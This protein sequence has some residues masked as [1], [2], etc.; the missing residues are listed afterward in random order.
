VPRRDF[1]LAGRAGSLLALLALS[2]TVLLATPA[3]ASGCSV[4]RAQRGRN[5]SYAQVSAAIDAAAGRHRVPPPLLKAIAWKESGWQ[6]FWS[7]GR[8][9]VSGDCGVGIMQI[10]GGSWDY[11]RLGRDYLYNVDAG[12]RVLAAKMAASSRNVPAALRPDEPRVMENWYR[13]AYRYN[14]SG[15]AAER[16]A[17][18]V[19][20]LVVTPPSGIAPWSPSVR[21]TNPKHVLRGY[22][23]T[24][25]H[26]YVARV[27]GMWRSTLGT[28]RG[29]V[30]RAD[31]LATRA[32]TT[33]GRSLEGD[34]ATWV[35]LTARNL[36]YATWT[37]STV[38]LRT[39]PVGRRSVLQSGRWIDPTTPAR[40]TTS[41]PTGGTARY[42]VYAVA[43]RVASSR[44]AHEWFAPA[45]AGTPVAGA[46]AGARW[47]LQPAAAP[48]AGVSAAPRYVTERSTD[49]TAQIL[50]AAADPAPGAGLLR[51]ELT[52]RQVCEGCPWSAPQPVGSAPR[53]A[54]GAP[55]R[56]EVKVR[57]IDRAG[58]YSAWSEPREVVVPHDDTAALLTY[59]GSWAP[60]ADAGTWQGSLAATSDAG[61]TVTIAEDGSRLAVI[62]TRAPDAAPFRVWVDGVLHSVVEPV[63]ETVQHRALLWELDVPDG[64]HELRVELVGP[65]QLSSTRTSETLPTLR[66]DALA[67]A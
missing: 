4:A 12:A 56:H 44:A 42:Q 33:P 17:D 57:A 43:A 65:D 51:V 3:T 32:A 40:L 59:T 47:T 58:H 61:S 20:A 19:F 39:Y 23:P 41:V 8:A 13:A 60:Q 6:Q 45:V 49:A 34:Q 24:S 31:Y 52:Q 38:P 11:A 10:T 9:K 53:V 22:R 37:P 29:P 67:V 54:L 5:P 35:V 27:D 2:L 55:G 30:L 1:P 26:A 66:V 64:R 15:A 18:S 25:G 36:G 28:T 14:G 21:L 48:T 62:G 63:S 7:D 46:A 50:V 16:Y